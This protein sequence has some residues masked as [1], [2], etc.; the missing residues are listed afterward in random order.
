MKISSQIGHEVSPYPTFSGIELLSDRQ[1]RKARFTFGF[2][3]YTIDILRN[4]SLGV[5][6]A[7]RSDLY[8]I[9]QWGL[10]TILVAEFKM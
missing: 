7:I 1:P 3:F 5:P 6:N 4:L 9:I 2:A 8:L 10:E